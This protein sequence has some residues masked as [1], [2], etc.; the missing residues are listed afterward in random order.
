MAINKT[1]K[2]Q[3]LQKLSEVF[4]QAKTL[5]FVRFS[6]LSVSE[7]SAMRKA[8]RDEQVGYYVAKKTLIRRAL[9]ERSYTGTLPEI[10]GKIALVWSATDEITP[11][12]AVY[13]QG[14]K[15]KE[16]LFIEGGV[17]NGTFVDATYMQALAIIPPMPVLRGMFVNVI[18]A[19]IQGLVMALNQICEQKA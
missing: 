1:K 8:L 19:P 18:N 2:E 6:G 5:V 15:K 4:S 12:R 10:P 16:T 13:E 9:S 7:T 17:F 3:I 11:A 14:K